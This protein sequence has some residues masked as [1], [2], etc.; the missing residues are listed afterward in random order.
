MACWCIEVDDKAC[1]LHVS[2]LS[3][4]AVMGL[5]IYIAVEGLDWDYEYSI[6]MSLWNEVQDGICWMLSYYDVIGSLDLYVVFKWVT[7]LSVIHV[8]SCVKYVSYDLW[9]FHECL[10]LS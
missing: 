6:L 9:C 3:M 8:V 10:G 7:R 4:C 5:H 1:G 2:S